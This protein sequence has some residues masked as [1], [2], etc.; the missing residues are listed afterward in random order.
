MKTLFEHRLPGT[1][2]IN[3][4]QHRFLVWNRPIR[5]AKKGHGTD[6]M[7]RKRFSSIAT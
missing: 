5:D 4:L 3:Q 7:T 1:D 2:P 6:L